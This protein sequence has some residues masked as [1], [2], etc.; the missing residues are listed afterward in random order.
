MMI[1]PY[2]GFFNEERDDEHAPPY[3]MCELCY[4]YDICKKAEMQE[5]LITGVED[6]WI[7]V[8]QEA[9]EEYLKAKERI[10]NKGDNHE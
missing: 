9:W 10:N 4:R 6:G 8:D 3:G 2:C 1:S 7:K 5:A